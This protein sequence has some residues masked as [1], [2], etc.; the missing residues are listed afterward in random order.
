MTTEHLLQHCQLH[1]AVRWDMWP[2]PIP[3]RDRLYGNPNE[4]KR[5]ATFVRKASPFSLR[6]RRERLCQLYSADSD[7]GIVGGAL[8]SEAKSLSVWQLWF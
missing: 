2:E 4:L 7:T 6:R 8:D 1:A 3:L 5:T